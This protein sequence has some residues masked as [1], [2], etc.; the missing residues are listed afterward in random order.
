MENQNMFNTFANM[1]KQAVETFNQAAESMK[2]AM[3]NP[4]NVDFNSDFFKKWYDSQMAWFNQ[5]K[6]ENNNQA[7]EFFQNWMNS[8]TDIA[9]KWFE[10][11][12]GLMNNMPAMDMNNTNW[13]A[14][15]NNMM[16]MFNTWKETMTTSYNE[17]MTNFN[18]GTNKETFSGM[19]NNADMYMKMFQ[20]WMPMM[21]SLQDKSFTTESFRNMFNAPMYKEM[22]D[23]M[24]NMQPDFMKNMFTSNMGGMKDQMGNMMDMNKNMFDNM[25]NMMNQNMNSMMPADMFSTM[26]NNYNNM[27]NQMNN[28]VAPLAKLMPNGNQKQQMENMKELSNHMNVYNLKNTQ[29]QY[30]MYTTGMKAMDEVAENLYSRMRN[31]EDFNSF[32]NVYQ[33][34]LN[35]NDKHFVALFESEEYS[36]LMSEV[37]ALQLGLKKKIENQM[38]KAFSNLPLINR[39]E[40]DELYLTI[41]GLK[42]RISML[43]RQLDAETSTEAET[44]ET[45]TRKG[46]KANA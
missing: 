16:N 36:K 8:Q 32:I 9:K 14:N 21:K 19:F 5:H 15:Y 12:Q 37:S 22:M 24:F 34:W 7:F 23:K 6:G 28:A 45:K 3:G 29:M 2:N 18:N 4:A 11:S 40:M 44:K 39:S 38:E 46:T 20:F 13:N 33:E 31:G 30:M 17:M 1:Q 35:T 43:E 26:L 41:Q 10:A 27:F 25:K 42:S